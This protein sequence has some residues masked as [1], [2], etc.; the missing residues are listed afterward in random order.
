MMVSAKSF[1]QQTTFHLNVTNATILEVFEKIEQQSEIGFLFRES[2]L[3]LDKKYDINKSEATLTEILDVVLADGAVNYRIIENNVIIFKKQQS[4]AAVQRQK[5][6]VV[7]GVVIDTTGDPIPGANVYIK[8]NP[9]HGVITGVDGSYNIEVDSPDEVI[10]FS[11]IG[12][13][14]QELNV[15]GRN[16]INVF[17]VE[18]ITSLNEVVVVGYGTQ[19]KVNITGAVSVV[20]SELIEDRPVTNAQQALQGMA[21]GLQLNSTIHGGE[22]GSEMKMLIRG[23]M[24]LDP[25]VEAEPLVLIDGIPMGMNDIDPNDIETIS[26]LKDAA[27]SSIYGA[28]AAFGVI[29]I[30]TKR[31][32]K[33][34]AGK[35]SYSTNIS[36]AK[37]TI[38]PE[39]A[40]AM[41]FALAMN[42]SL[43]NTGSSNVYYDEETLD[44]LAQNI[45]N[46]G[47]APTMFGTPNGMEWD[48]GKMGLGA[49]ANTDWESLLFKKWSTRQKHNLTFKGGS[50]KVSYY[51]SGSYYDEPGMLKEGDESLQRYTFDGKIDAEV[52]SWAKIALLVKYNYTE[53]DYPWDEK[54]NRG[55]IFDMI[56]KL[57]PTMPAKYPGTDVWT[58]ESGFEKWKTTRD[59]KADRQLILSPR[60]II[61]PIKGWVTNMELNYRTNDVRNTLTAGD[62]PW[63]RPNGDYVYVPGRPSTEYRA[64]MR[65][66]SYLSPTIHTSYSRSI[67]D[68][69]MRVMAGFQQEEY[70]YFGLDGTT[71]HLL[72]DDIPSFGTAVGETEIGDQIGH[73]GTQSFFGRVNY[74]FKEKYLFEANIRRDGSSR[75]REGRRWGAFPSFSAGW[76]MSR[77]NFFPLKEQIDFMKIR[78]SYGTIGSQQVENYLH[79]PTM[80][81]EQQTQYLWSGQRKRVVFA[82]GLGSQNLTWQST[83]TLDLGLEIRALNHRLATTF[84]LYSTS[85]IDGFSDGPTVPG[86]LGTASPRMNYGE[87]TVKGWEMEITWRDKIG[88]LS[89][90]FRGVLSDYKRTMDKWDNPTNF[91]GNNSL[92]AGQVLGEIW[93]FETDGLF[94]T[95]A[96]VDSWHDQ[97]FFHAKAFEAGDM[98]YVDQTGD[99]V[100]DQGDLTLDD[101][102]DMKVIGNSTPRYQYGFGGN[103][104]YKGFDF[105]FMFQGVGKRDLSIQQHSMRG[106]A[107]GKF[108]ATVYKEHMDYWRDESSPLGANP[109]AFFPRPYS[110][111]PGL[112]KKNWN[113]ASTHFLQNGAYLRLKNVTLGYT[114][115][116]SL[117]KKVKISNVRIYLSGENLLTFTDLLFFDPE[118]FAGRNLGQG[119]H[120]GKAP[121]PLSKVISGGLTV[122]F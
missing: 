10:V 86:V 93:G 45:A 112:N 38:R 111:N 37:P 100:I 120:T 105:S 70:E 36:F 119:T 24:S 90:G 4:Q 14:D 3:D 50:E 74:N 91:L 25:D 55:R 8:D 113:Y 85:T 115:P 114:V 13:I 118:G 96:E 108:H 39:I 49:A 41:D 60:L 94:Q 61:E 83:K 57:K 52:T 109:D 87:I 76:V 80:N 64:A 9:Q 19:K 23:M 48:I 89:Y 34:E 27:S 102:G 20:D 116:E 56:S 51:V 29:L 66:D 6:M 110:Q 92:Y 53:I 88:D 2:E 81:S 63:V 104:A 75:F 58:E 18:E 77:E 54:Y 12:Y 68:H 65:A 73:W 17:L 107:Q 30:T 28:R 40:G 46:P 22:P 43:A 21:P 78:G 71:Y 99:G 5:Q 7:R 98:K 47:S 1:A 72:S 31:G 103:A 44:R 26:V 32:G 16:S 15:A 67:G 62:Y 106:P 97:S 101:H 11:F 35:F 95:D 82:P 42:E 84:G 122:N 79:V 33:N 59:V 69:N 117:T 121:Y